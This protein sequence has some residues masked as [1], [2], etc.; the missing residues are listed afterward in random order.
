MIKERFI[1]LRKRTEAIC[2]PLQLEDFSVQPITDASPP[3]WHL[4]HTTWFFEQFV[5]VK[6]KKEYKLFDDDFSYLFNSYYNHVGKRIL[7]PNRGLM[8][9]PWFLKFWIIAAM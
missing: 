6:Y 2:E 5:L 1:A 8:T 9:R 3:K 7:R 4:A